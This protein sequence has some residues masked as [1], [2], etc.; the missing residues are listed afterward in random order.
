MLMDRDR[1]PEADAF[2]FIQKTAM[3]HRTKMRTVA[4]Q[5]IDGT[6]PSD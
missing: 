3:Q 4:Q 5:I 2:S 6:L 1:M